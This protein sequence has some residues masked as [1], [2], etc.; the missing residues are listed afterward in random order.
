MVSVSK[1]YETDIITLFHASGDFHYRHRW[2]E[3]VKQVEELNHFLPRVGMRCRCVLE[4]GE[5]I[6]YSNSYD[7][8]S[9]RIEFTEAEEGRGSVTHYLLEAIEPQ[10]SRLTI[11][12]YQG[13]KAL[14]EMI[15]RLTR[16]K[17]MEQDLVKSLEKLVPLV[18]EI[19]IPRQVE[20]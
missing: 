11:E 16:K 15:F 6:T 7:Y 2:R 3:G 4:G 9:D 17:T 10:R 19:R 1:E 14:A 5:V 20:A 13:G 18:R 12:Y 8:A